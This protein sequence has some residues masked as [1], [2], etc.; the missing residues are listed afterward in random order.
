MLL[1]LIDLSEEKLEENYL[2]VRNELSKYDKI[3]SKKK[4]IIVFN[5]SDLFEKKEIDKK[6]KIFKKKIKKKFEIISVVADKN[7]TDLRK[8]LLKNV[9]K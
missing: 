3:L 6:L 5:K 8:I 1:H 7:L 9:Y 4:E 2:N